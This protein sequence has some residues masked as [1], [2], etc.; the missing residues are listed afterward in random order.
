MNLDAFVLLITA[1]HSWGTS[2]C[3]P[4]ILMSTKWRGPAI[5]FLSNQRSRADMKI[6]RLACQQSAQTPRT[7]TLSPTG[8]GENQMAFIYLGN[9]DVQISA[10]LGRRGRLGRKTEEWESA[11]DNDEKAFL[12]PKM[13]MSH[14]IVRTDSLRP[15]YVR[16]PRTSLVTVV[17]GHR[18]YDK[19]EKE[20]G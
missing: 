13:A 18:G 19:P 20:V 11:R 8:L 9:A 2:P 10:K 16:G 3:P 14:P 17:T 5:C 12:A 6:G 15:G 4:L 7:T 1:T